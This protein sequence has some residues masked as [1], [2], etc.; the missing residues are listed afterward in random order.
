MNINIYKI[1]S[2]LSILFN[3]LH[4]FIKVY[5]IYYII[6][7]NYNNL[8]IIKLCIYMLNFTVVVIH[9]SYCHEHHV[10]VVGLA[11]L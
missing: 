8:Q 11:S 7:K 1:L 5:S 9:Y 2:I 3:A 6:L 10:V 4:V